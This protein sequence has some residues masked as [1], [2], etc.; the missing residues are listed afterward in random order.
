MFAQTDKI[1]PSFEQFISLRSAFSPSIS[2]D[3]KHVLFS[4]R[5]TDWKANRY[6]TEIWI[7]KDGQEPFQLTYTPEGSSSNAKWSPYGT[8][9]SFVAKRGEKSQIYVIRTAGG[10]ARA[11]TNMDKSINDYEWA[12]DGKHFYLTLTEEESKEEKDRKKRLGTFSVEDQEYKRSHL[13]IVEFDPE[14]KNP[15]EFP[16]MEEDSTETDCIKFPEPE[17]LTEGEFTVTDFAVSPDGKL[18]AVQHQPDPLIN[19]FFDSDISIL[20][21]TTKELVPFVNNSSYDGGFVWSPDSKSLLYSSNLENRTSNYYANNQ[22]FIQLVENGQARQIATEFDENLYGFAWTPLGIFASANQK[23]NTSIFQINPKS[24]DASLFGGY[25]NMSTFGV[26][27]SK[28]GKYMAFSANSPSMTSEI[29]LSETEKTN[30]RKLTDM[31]A[32]FKDWQIA[33]SEV[34]SWKKPGWDKD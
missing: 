25:A 22:Y 27:F 33:R 9:I 2:P 7:S 3:G 10:E 5:T 18:I 34:I 30:G 26:S 21:T 31:S 13:W 6:D 16:C 24:G 14:M 32:Q 1:V 8:W 11:A 12:P 4:V 19:S 23:T 29:F 15:T 20:N 17:Q 28:D